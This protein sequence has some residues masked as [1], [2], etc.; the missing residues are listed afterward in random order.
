M[1]SHAFTNITL[2]I[3]GFL[4]FLVSIFSPEG[5]MPICKEECVVIVYFL[6][7]RLQQLG[8]YVQEI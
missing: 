3:S 4:G 5:Y 6:E 1:E 2:G 7:V 8:M